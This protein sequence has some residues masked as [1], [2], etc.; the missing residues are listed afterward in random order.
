MAADAAEPPE[1]SRVSVDH[2]N[3]TAVP[4]ERCQQLFDMAQMR[5]AAAA[6]PQIPRGGPA[7]MQ[8]VGRRDR[9]QADIAMAFTDQA[10]R[11]EKRR[12]SRDL[13]AR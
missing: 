10:D 7:A 5:Q 12:H 3:E 4:A 1:R 11:L 9:Q 6:A 13:A 2:G 8:A